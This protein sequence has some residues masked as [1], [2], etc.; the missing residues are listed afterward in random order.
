VALLKALVATVEIQFSVVAVL[1]LVPQ[2]E[3][4]AVQGLQTQAAVALVEMGLAAQ[5]A[6]V[7]LVLS[8]WNTKKWTP[9]R[10][11]MSALASF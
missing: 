8:L 3:E 5:A 11:S 1:V 4:L 2:M 10:S 7:G 6:L 9:K